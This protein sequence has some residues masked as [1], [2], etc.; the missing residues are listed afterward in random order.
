M[1]K[2][3]YG[4]TNCYLYHAIRYAPN[5]GT[6]GHRYKLYV[7]HLRKLILSTHFMYRVVPI[8]NLLPDQCFSPD[9]YN[10]FRI[11]ICKIDFSRFLVCEV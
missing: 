3:T 8:W 6:R 9:I 1:F 10:F 11:K 7:A 2:L 4:L 5:V